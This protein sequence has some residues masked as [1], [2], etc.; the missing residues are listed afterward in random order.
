VDQSP[1]Y[2]LQ[3]TGLTFATPALLT[4]PFENVQGIIPR[5]IAGYLSTDD[6]ASFTRLGDSYENAGF[7]MASLSRLGQV[8]AGY[9]HGAADDIACSVDAG[10]N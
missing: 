6:C 2:E 4:I 3:P 5:E 1:I 8:F 9:P 7:I 10:A